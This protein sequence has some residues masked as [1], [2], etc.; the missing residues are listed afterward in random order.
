MIKEHKVF[1]FIC[2]NCKCDLFDNEDSIGITDIDI[3]SS[4]A[5]ASNWIIDGDKHYCPDCYFFDEDNKIEIK[6]K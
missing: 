2:D 4:I 6:S 3:V 5:D 1:T